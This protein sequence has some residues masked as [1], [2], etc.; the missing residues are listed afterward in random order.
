[1]TIDEMKEMLA[2]KDGR[3]R[4][5]PQHIEESIQT[6]CVNWFRL[7]YP[8]YIILAIPN[9]GS[10]NEREA[11]NMKRAG[12]LAGASDLLVIGTRAVLFIEMK[13]PKGKQQ[14]TQKIFQKNVER[15]GHTYAICHSL[16][17]FQLTIERW[18]KEKYEYG[19]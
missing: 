10:R 18:I 15:L 2:K 6:V 19:T 9:G 4:R 16:Q 1:M 11:A 12:V 17:E 8:N 3:S 14:S 5:K 7:E 13:G